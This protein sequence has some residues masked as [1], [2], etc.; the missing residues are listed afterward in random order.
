MITRKI[1]IIIKIIDEPGGA[2]IPLSQIGGFIELF[3]IPTTL[4]YGPV[5][6]EA[7][8][9]SSSSSSS[10]TTKRAIQRQRQQQKIR[11]QEEKC[12]TIN[13]VPLFT[14][15]TKCNNVHKSEND[16]SYYHIRLS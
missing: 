15:S 8:S 14:I 5:I 4:W 6:V 1:I 12:E 9:S 2:I 7:S 3:P 10:S 13:F 16:N 11:Q